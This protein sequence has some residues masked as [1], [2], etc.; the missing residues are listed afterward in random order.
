MNKAQNFT[1]SKLADIPDEPYCLP[2]AAL[3]PVV[4]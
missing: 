3:Q 1:E 2:M 4:R